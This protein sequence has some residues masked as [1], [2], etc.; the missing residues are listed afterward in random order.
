MPRG[1][2]SQ[3]AAC[4]PSSGVGAV[5]AWHCGRF[6]RIIGS[7]S[8]I[9]EGSINPTTLILWLSNVRQSQNVLKPVN[10]GRFSVLNIRWPNHGQLDNALGSSVDSVL[11]N[12]GLFRLCGIHDGPLDSAPLTSLRSAAPRSRTSWLSTP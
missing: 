12:Y 1:W 6:N 3:Q 4:D 7:E 5:P 9:I 10:C 2:R 8:C 11:T